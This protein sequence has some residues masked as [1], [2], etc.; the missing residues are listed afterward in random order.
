VTQAIRSLAQL[1][2]FEVVQQG[3]GVA[4]VRA[5]VGPEHVNM[6]GTVHGGFVFALADE[7]LAVAANSH[8]PQAVALVASIHFTRPARK[9]DVLVADAREV[10][11]GRTTATY[12]VGVACEGRPVALFTGTV[13]RRG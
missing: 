3:P 2:G 12:E 10:S 6:H 11:L 4:S 1:L 5:T 7:A 9:G 8:G 13:H